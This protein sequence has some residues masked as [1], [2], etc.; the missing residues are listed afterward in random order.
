MPVIAQH[1]L[2][3]TLTSMLSH[4]GSA[5]TVHIGQYTNVN[6]C[7]PDIVKVLLF[8]EQVSVHRPDITSFGI[9]TQSTFKCY[10]ASF[11]ISILELILGK[12]LYHINICTIRTS[13]ISLAT[14]ILEFFISF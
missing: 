9:V 11:N 12:L 4:Q 13:V 10:L 7:I 2:Y 8:D 3:S 5:C 1:I 6:S 14:V